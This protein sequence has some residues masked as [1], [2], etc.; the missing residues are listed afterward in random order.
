MVVRHD[1]GA[2]AILAPRDT[3]VAGNVTPRATVHNYGSVPET[4]KVFF[5]I[6][7]GAPWI[8]SL[9]AVVG[10]GRDSTLNFRTWP[11]TVGSY[12]GKCSTAL[13]TDADRSNDTLRVP[14]FVVQHDVGAVAILAPRDTLVAGPVAPRATVHNYGTVP[15]TFK[16]FFRISGGTSWIDSLTAVVGV[17]RDSTLNFRNWAATVGNYSGRCSTALATDAVRSND[18]LRA[19][20]VVVRHDVGAVA[21]AA[22]NGMVPPGVTQP[23]ATV[24]NYGTI[25]E[26]FKVFFRIAGTTSYADSVTLTLANGLDSLVRFANWNAV[27]G[28]YTGRCSTALATD[29]NR[30]NDTVSNAFT[31]A[32]SDVGSWPSSRHGTAYAGAAAAAGAGAQLRLAG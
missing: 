5:R 30:S 3:V 11:A 7:G 2:V 24:H 19:Q 4:F 1:V 20:F 17:G 25:P 27:A 15:E 31:V 10:V 9:T 32:Q 26:T 18:T 22:P 14:F 8:D 28:S 29:A 6:T 13:A 12:S 23:R 21:I 16:V